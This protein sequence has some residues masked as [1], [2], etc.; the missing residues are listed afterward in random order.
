MP[1]GEPG[2]NPQSSQRDAEHAEQPGSPESSLLDLVSAIVVLIR[3]TWHDRWSL[4]KAETR[5]AMKSVLLLGF[6]ILSVAIVLL[7]IWV[8]LLG[9]ASY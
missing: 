5:L 7:L 8:L 2:D 4:I 9:G 1:A 3:Q 6:A